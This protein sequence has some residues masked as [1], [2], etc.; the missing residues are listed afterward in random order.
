[1]PFPQKC[2]TVTQTAFPHSTFI[3]NGV[4]SSQDIHNS[5]A[6]YSSTAWLAAAEY[7][8]VIACFAFAEVVKGDLIL[9]QKN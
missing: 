7:N 9:E 4:K 1:M 6:T 8:F 3:L 5:P 2:Y